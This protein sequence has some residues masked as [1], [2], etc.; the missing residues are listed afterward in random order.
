[1][2]TYLIVL[3]LIVFAMQFVMGFKVG[4][5]RGK[6]KV[7]VPATTGSKKFERVFRAHQN[8]LEYVPMFLV[9][10]WLAEMTGWNC[11]WVGWI[12]VIWILSRIWYFMEYCKGTKLRGKTF[13]LSLLCLVLLVWTIIYNLIM[14]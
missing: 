2:E 9:F 4:M 12:A 8:T 6:Y 10:M 11:Y 1:M 13:M 7:P 14:M 3:T 5:A